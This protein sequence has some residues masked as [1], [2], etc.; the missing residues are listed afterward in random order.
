[1]DAP[2]SYEQKDDI[3]LVVMNDGKVNAYGPAMIAALAS[4]LDRAC[5]EAQAVVIAG[6]PG[7][8]CAGYDLKIIRGADP[9]VAIA[10]RGMGR[11]V[12]LQTYLPPQPVV[13][14]CTGHTLA[15]GALLSLAGDYRIGSRGD[16]KIGLNETSI[17]LALPAYGIELAR[18]RLRP[19]ALCAATLGA[20]IYCPE[21]ALEV[22]YFD[23]IIDSTLVIEHALKVAKRMVKLDKKAFA[24]TKRVLRDP[25]VQR[26]S[27][28]VE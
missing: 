18:D 13:M 28:A 5:C 27:K 22:G 25:T 14:A 21:G 3:A 20:E 11:G 19:N 6:R 12:I 1:M 9:D 15:A 16:F 10:M 4:A 23:S 2:L 26:I 8:F 17:G 24:E 7:V